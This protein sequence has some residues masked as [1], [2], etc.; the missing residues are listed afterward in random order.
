MNR[1]PV[2]GARFA[3]VL[4]FGKT[5]CFF[6]E[7]RRDKVSLS[8]RDD[9]EATCAFT[10]CG[11]PHTDMTDRLSCGRYLPTAFNTPSGVYTEP[12]R[13][14]FSFN[15]LAFYTEFGIPMGNTRGAPT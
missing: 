10:L 12:I 13:G 15:L 2:K 7:V 11:Y 14:R 8:R 5:F 9:S 3:G 1:V 6:E 4:L